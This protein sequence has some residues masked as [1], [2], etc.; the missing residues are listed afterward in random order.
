MITHANVFVALSTDHLPVTI[1][2]S[3][4]SGNSTVLYFQTKIMLEKQKKILFKPFTVTKVL[5]RIP[6]QLKLEL[7][8][9]EIRKF[10]INYSKEWEENKILLENKLKELEGNLK[11]EDN[12]QSDNIHKIELDSMYHHIAE[13]IRIQSK[14]D[15]YKPSKKSTKFFF[16]S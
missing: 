5:L 13:G 1:S 14:F 10:T 4:T 3:G 16:E 9:Y 7:L 15:W 6:P 11:M 2:I 8:K 12:I